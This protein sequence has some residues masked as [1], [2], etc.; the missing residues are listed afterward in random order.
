MHF[1]TIPIPS[2]A[3]VTRQSAIYCTEDEG[4]EEAISGVT[5]LDILDNCRQNCDG[6]PSVAE[7]SIYSVVVSFGLTMICGSK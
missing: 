3:V 6:I 5:S 2:M 1:M 4:L 7:L